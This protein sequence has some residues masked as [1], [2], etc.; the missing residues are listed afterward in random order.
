MNI[1]E[2]KKR[3]NTKGFTREE[4][5][6]GLQI[7]DK[8]FTIDTCMGGRYWT[9]SVKSEGKWKTLCTRALFN[10]AINKITSQF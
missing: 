2:F 7:E 5:W 9:V 1:Q 3:A 8:L 10:T 6:N 4:M